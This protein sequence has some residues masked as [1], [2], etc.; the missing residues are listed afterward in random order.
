MN[1]DNRQKNLLPEILEKVKKSKLF[2]D[3][4]NDVEKLFNTLTNQSPALKAEDWKTFL[5][6]FPLL[7]NNVLVIRMFIVPMKVFTVEHGAVLTNEVIP[8][9]WGQ[10]IKSPTWQ[11]NGTLD[12]YE[13]NINLKLDKLTV[14]FQASANSKT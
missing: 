8:I 4:K 3:R 6:L 10:I 7:H 12:P 11:K 2:V 9:I 5:E 13:K 1:L 14:K